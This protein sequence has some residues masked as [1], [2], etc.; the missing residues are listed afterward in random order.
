M[1]DLRAFFHQFY[2]PNNA[3][4]AIVGDFDPVQLKP[5]IEKYFGPIPSVPEVKPN[6]IPQPM[7]TSVVRERIEDKLAELPRL[8]LAW[9]GVKPFAADEPAGDVLSSILGSGKTSRLYKKLVFEK[10]VATSTAAYNQTSEL[11]GYF[12]A[13]ALAKAGHTTEELQPMVDQIIDDIKKNGVTAAE[14][15]RARRKI[16]AQLLRGVE[17]I[18]GFGGK[19]DQLNHYQ[20]ELGDPGYLSKDIARYRAVTAEEVQAFANK[21]LLTDRRLIL[22]TV[23]ASKTVSAR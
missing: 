5:L 2:A 13:S 8:T 7:L 9:N 21:Y 18:G 16:I 11:G 15:E 10:Q 3:S 4:L 12:V 17:R 1:D 20:T 22:E 14:L 6:E 23:P 19:A